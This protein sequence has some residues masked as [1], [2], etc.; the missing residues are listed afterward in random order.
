[1]KTF[2]TIIKIASNTLAG[3]SLSIGLLMHNGRKFWLQFSEERKAV[4]KKL[5][6]N[7]ADI[8]DFVTKQIKDKVEEMNGSLNAADHSL[9]SGEGVLN[10]EK[11][12]HISNYSN[13]VVRFSEPAFLNDKVNDEKFQQLFTLLVDKPS[14]KIKPVVD[15]RDIVFREKIQ[16]N[17]IERGSKYSAY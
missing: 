4:A 12:L 9:F 13:G 5:L 15:E 8:V 14:Q 17:L 11:L 2:Y 10:A 3:D 16:T 6:A 7:K 1:M